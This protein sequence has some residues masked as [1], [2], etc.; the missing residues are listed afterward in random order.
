MPSYG[1]FNIIFCLQDFASHD[2]R[3][4]NLISAE[5]YNTGVY[6]KRF[7]EVV[8]RDVSMERIFFLLLRWFYNE[9]MMPGMIF[10]SQ[11]GF[12]RYFYI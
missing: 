8:C 6:D 10:L 12:K 11:A 7:T 5:K 4:G 3:E 9:K 1:I 2:R